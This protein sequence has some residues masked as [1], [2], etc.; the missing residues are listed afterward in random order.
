M[1]KFNVRNQSINRIDGFS[2][3]EGSVNYLIAEFNFKTDDWNGTLKTAIFKNPS[4]KKEYD[5][6]LDEDHC[7]VPWEAISDDGKCEVAV[8]GLTEDY[9]IT[10]DIERFS[11]KPTLTGGTATQ[12]PTPTVYEQLLEKLNN[13]S[14]GTF[15]DWGE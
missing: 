10:T 6:I 7:V 1:I 4:S 5:A 12:E 15:A 3:A 9:K 8:Y 2:P 14:G 13:I 11:V